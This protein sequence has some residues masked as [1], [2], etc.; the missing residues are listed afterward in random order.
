MKLPLKALD[1]LEGAE[2]S[3]K[4]DA[5]AVVRIAAIQGAKRCAELIP[6]AHPVALAS[7]TADVA[8]SRE[9]G[10]AAVTCTARCE[11]RTG[12]EMEALMGASVGALA[13]YGERDASGV[14]G[15]VGRGSPWLPE[16]AGAR[17]CIRDWEGLGT[18]YVATCAADMLKSVD[19]GIEIGPVRLLVKTGGKSGVW[20]HSMGRVSEQEYEK[21]RQAA[22]G[23]HPGTGWA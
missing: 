23:R 2:V 16:T 11:G 8:I 22:G 6:L 17:Q 13:L 3:R 7:V 12:V 5:A 20:H 21:M 15:H 19:K 4:G 18:E 10:A 9:R 1:A 14:E